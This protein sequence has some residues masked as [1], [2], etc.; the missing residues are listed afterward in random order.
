[1][2]VAPVTT[3]HA[4]VASVQ[5]GSEVEDG[6]LEEELLDEGTQLA[7]LEVPSVTEGEVMLDELSDDSIRVAH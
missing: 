7:E 5:D 1:M 4:V 6:W 2:A 3:P